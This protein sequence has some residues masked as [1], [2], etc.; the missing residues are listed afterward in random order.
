VAVGGSTGQV[1]AKT[2]ATDYATEWVTPTPVG[3]Q[4]V[5]LATNSTLTDERVLTAGTGITVTDGGAGSN[6]TVATSAILPTIIDA[7]GD[8]LVG[9]TADTVARLAVGSTNGHVLTVD[10]S[11]TEGIKWAAPSGNAVDDDQN[12]LAVQVFS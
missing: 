9:T 11:T 1:L 12:I 5:T 6:V 7:K 4:Y 3:A 10:S 2:S 8:L